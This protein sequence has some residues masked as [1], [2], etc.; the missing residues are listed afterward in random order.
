MT[1]PPILISDWK[2]RH[3]G[4]LVGFFTACLPSGLTLHELMLHHRDGAWWISFPSKPMLGIDGSALRDERGKI[5]YGAPLTEFAS[6]QARDRFNAGVLDALRL[7]HPAIFAAD[8]E[9]VT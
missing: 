3:S 9:V 4:T 8:T 6:R 7:A 2:P 1:S 5:R